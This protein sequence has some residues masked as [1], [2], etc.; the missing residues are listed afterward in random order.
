MAVVTA[1]LLVVFVLRR[2]GSGEAESQ[3]GDPSFEVGRAETLARAV[4]R[5]RTPLL[6]QDL[7]Q[8][9]RDIWVQH[10][11]PDPKAGWRAF[12]AHAPDQ[13]RTCQLRWDADARRFDDPCTGR[14]YPPD[15]AGLTQYRVEVRDGR[16]V[17]D[18]RAPAP[19]G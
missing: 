12:E 15:G 8:R 4:E 17:V 10:E 1:V 18:L 19:P 2:V 13:P 7:L 11:G 14:T 5:D 6:F 16:L 3:L 9:S